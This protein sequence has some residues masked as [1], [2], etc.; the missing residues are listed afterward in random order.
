MAINKPEPTGGDKLE[1]CGVEE[2]A[3]DALMRPWG[4][5]TGTQTR[6]RNQ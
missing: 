6:M 2:S 4:R 3:E 5:T 1:T